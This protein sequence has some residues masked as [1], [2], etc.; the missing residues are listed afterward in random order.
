VIDVLSASA[1]DAEYDHNV[2]AALDNFAVGSR[3]IAVILTVS[4]ANI[5][6]DDLHFGA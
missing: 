2:T 1:T 5:N 3:Q 4:V 6:Y